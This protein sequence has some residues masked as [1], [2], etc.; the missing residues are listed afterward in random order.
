MHLVA[1]NPTSQASADGR[2]VLDQAA[3]AA[4]AAEPDVRVVTEMRSGDVATELLDEAETAGILVLGTRGHGGVM[5]LMLGSV[6]QKVAGHTTG[7]VVVVRA[8]SDG[9]KGEIVVGFD[10]SEESRRA[11]AFAFEEAM[12]RQTR[13]RIVSAWAAPVV[14]GFEVG[15][16]DSD[17]TLRTSKEFVKAELA[18]WKEKYPLV[19]VDASVRIGH[20][21]AVL[22]DAS[23]AAD[24]VVLGSRGRSAIRSTFLGSVGND[25]LLHAKS[26]VAV[27]GPE[28]SEVIGGV[29]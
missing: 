28:P 9:D 1:R 5:G 26:P 10:G 19:D 18:A 7:A 21:A 23:T 6:C 24:L 13:L 12:A 22:T 17:E 16:I 3:A 15:W 27:V 2:A 11:V 29:V 14:T 8:A 20:A 25:V 4:R